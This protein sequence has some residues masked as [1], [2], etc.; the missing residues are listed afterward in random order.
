MGT[1]SC[2]GGPGATHQTA[3]LEFPGSTPGSG[4]DIYV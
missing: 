4:K 2:V 1:F 3:V